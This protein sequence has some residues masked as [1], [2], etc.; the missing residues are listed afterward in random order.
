MRVIKRDGTVVPMDFKE[1]QVRLTHFT[2]HPTVLSKVDAAF[3]TQQVI[4]HLRDME[5][6]EDIDNITAKIATEHYDK[7]FEY[8]K[9]AAR[10]AM[11]NHHK[12]TSDSFAE[13]I[14]R[15]HASL[16]KI[17]NPRIVEFI[18]KNADKLDAMIDYNR[19]YLFDYIGFQVLQNS[20]LLQIDGRPIERP[21][22]MLMREAIQVNVPYIFPQYS[23]ITPPPNSIDVFS[24]IKDCYDKLSAK[25]YTHATPT[26]FN[27]CSATPQLAS[28]FLIDI[29]DDT[30]DILKASNSAALIS[31]TSGGV[32][33]NF[34]NLRGKNALI[35]STGGRTKGTKYFMKGF[36]SWS[37]AFDQ[38]GGK[39]PGNFAIYQT[40][41]HPDLID[42]L[43]SRLPNATPED[44]C[45][46]LH[47]GLWV[48]DL[49]MKRLLSNGTWTFFCSKVCPDLA[50]LWGEEYEAKYEEYEK[51]PSKVSS[52]M[53]CKE[54]FSHWFK[55]VK[56]S[57]YPYV[58]FKDSINKSN[59]QK[60]VGVIKSSN[61]CTEIMLHTSSRE[62]AVCNLASICLSAFVFDTW[63]REELGQDMD[64]RRALDHEFPKHP[65]FDFEAL[66]R[67]TGDIVENLNN[68]IDSTYYPTVETARSNFS[69]RPIGIG[70]QGLNDVFMK[71]KFEW[72][73]EKAA[74]INKYIAET[75]Y[76]AAVQMS[77]RLA[78][79]RYQQM[80]SIVD[81]GGIAEIC[82]YPPVIL[83]R[84]PELASENNVQEFIDIPDIPKTIGSYP[85]YNLGEGA[86]VKEK[87]HWEHYKGVTPRYN[88]EKV[89]THVNTYGMRNSMLIAYM[90]TASTSYIMGCTPCFEPPTGMTLVRKT[91][92]GNFTLVNKYAVHDLESRGLW[93]RDMKNEI[94]LSKGGG[95]IQNITRIPESLRRLYKNAFEI[96][97]ET[98]IKLAADRQPFICHA[99]S[100]NWFMQDP[101]LKTYLQMLFQAWRLELKTAM[102]YLRIETSSE[103]R[104][105][106][107]QSSRNPEGEAVGADEHFVEVDQSAYTPDSDDDAYE[108]LMCSS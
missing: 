73:S 49:F 41:H 2:S 57:G 6:T 56:N 89:R 61:L 25:Q 93:N 58:C 16:P 1:I 35:S 78:R 52:T 34:Q 107:R 27:S 63:T 54:I 71:F 74:E 48:P 12:I 79:R 77:T 68:V 105:T 99:Q 100:L 102:Y 32:G 11:N 91:L 47:I 14:V 64:K 70:I 92:A 43:K 51:D 76:Y 10:I 5:K 108:C 21:Q 3:L 44:A 39:R 98:L 31:R 28:C 18:A 50:N 37:A 29:E 40:M 26:L 9:F 87:F 33:L 65:W 81:G 66:I 36:E 88:W 15:F 84:F 20:Y 85:S 19:D 53:S 103:A 59:M 67:V 94:L 13:K 95:S 62:Q 75:I 83:E 72:E 24:R 96:P 101:N 60:N 8:A 104:K 55:S 38:G 42:F 82:T 80:L 46:K 90:P 106:V 30:F 45:P 7:S 4:Q 69:H 86:P 22:D 23:T 97:N 17:L